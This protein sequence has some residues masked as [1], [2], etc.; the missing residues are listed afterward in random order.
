LNCPIVRGAATTA[1][2]CPRRRDRALGRSP[3]LDAG[4]SAPSQRPGQEA[5]QISEPTPDTVTIERIENYL[6]QLTPQARGRLLNEIERLQT[7]G[8]ELKGADRIL[9]NLRAEFRKSGNTPERV[10]NPAR[11]F[12]QP[13]EP[14]LIDRM[15]EHANSGQISRGSLTVIWDWINQKLLPT[16]A[17]DYAEMIR[18]ALAADNEREAQKVAKTFQGKIVKSLE[19]NLKTADGLER[20]R[21]GL[22]A[23]TSSRA[24]IDDVCKMLSVLRSREVL[25]QFSA[26]LPAS[27]KNFAGP[28][29]VDVRRLIKALELKQPE[30]MPFAL[31][32]VARRLKTP[33]QLIA[34]AATPA[35]KKKPVPTAVP[36]FSMAVSMVVDQLDDKRL[37]LGFALR[38]NRIPVARE[39]L[40]E[41]DQIEQLLRDHADLLVACNCGDRLDE[42]MNTVN[43]IVE[44]EVQSIPGEVGHILGTRRRR[45]GSVKRQIAN[46]LTKS[47][48]ALSVSASTAKD[49]LGSS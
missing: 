20:T 28:V 37:M 18:K 11:Y 33:W 17:R 36:A 1:D 26:A 49:Y 16:M 31:V 42:L 2:G 46:L 32:I 35:G 48:N 29:V 43:T 8:E 24:A 47:R 6:Q 41:I 40:A 34:L 44:T 45:R 15:P 7:C 3:D 25:T 39:I 5:K 38:A 22:A 27:I 9:A 12:F 10:G 30:A 4:S 13:L 14:I 19:N 21:A 23:Y